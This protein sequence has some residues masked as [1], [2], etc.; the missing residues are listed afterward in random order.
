VGT[1]LLRWGVCGGV[2]RRIDDCVGG[3]ISEVVKEIGSGM[4]DLGGERS[5]R[6]GFLYRSLNTVLGSRVCVVCV[7]QRRRS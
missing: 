5:S 2:L 6:E 4:G 7:F 1:G 3:S